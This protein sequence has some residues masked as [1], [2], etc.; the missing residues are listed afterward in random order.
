MVLLARRA[1]QEHFASKRR[2]GADNEGI[3]LGSQ[4]AVLSGRHFPLFSAGDQG[5]VVRLDQEALNCDVLFEGATQP[6]PV[7]L[8]HLRIVQPPLD[9]KHQVTDCNQS[10]TKVQSTNCSASCSVGST[11]YSNQRN[12]LRGCEPDEW[13]EGCPRG[14]RGAP[15]SAGGGAHGSTASSSM[16]D[17]A[18]FQMVF[19]ES[20]ASK[21]ES[22]MI[23]V[24]DTLAWQSTLEEGPEASTSSPAN[25]QV[26]K[27]KTHRDDRK[28]LEGGASPEV[29]TFA[30]SNTFD[31][32]GDAAAVS[33]AL[34]ADVV[35]A[36]GRLVRVETLEARIQQLLEK[37]RAE[38]EELKSQL[39]KATTLGRQQQE[40]V[41][42]LEQ[43]MRN[44]RGTGPTASTGSMVLR[45]TSVVASEMSALATA[46]VGSSLAVS[47]SML[48]IATD[49]HSSGTGTPARSC[50]DPSDSLGRSRPLQSTTRLASSAS[51]GALATRPSSPRLHL[52]ATSSHVGAGGSV[53]P[54]LANTPSSCTVLGPSVTLP[55]EPAALGIPS[56]SS[57]RALSASTT[58]TRWA[59]QSVPAH[60]TTSPRPA[61]FLIARPNGATQQQQNTPRQQSLTPPGGAT[62]ITP[63][64]FMPGCRQGA[65]Q[66]QQQQWQQEDKPAPSEVK[67]G[68]SSG[69]T[70]SPSRSGVGGGMLNSPAAQPQFVKPVTARVLP[71]GSS[72]SVHVQ[73]SATGSL[74]APTNRSPAAVAAAAAAAATASQGGGATTL[75][76]GLSMAPSFGRIERM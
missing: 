59:C 9:S 46:P 29:F 48:P 2:E 35:G 70:L 22:V 24:S 42:A 5:E 40:R 34:V 28:I 58:P 53:S 12:S 6:V 62:P 67:C 33:A 26:N 74:L 73:A 18:G 55:V 36:D 69:G 45:P 31:G 16:T 30:G 21:G 66:Q 60:T 39:E 72:A 32:F 71:V 15:S 17:L 11:A 1:L 65:Q 68:T 3:E 64:A 63:L 25:K 44:M 51:S 13:E 38:T 19:G 20:P 7:A 57:R 43:Q 41:A 27:N 56:G 61:L 10:S 4:V 47:N 14:V 76:A 50:C 23:S 54:R 8:R 37:H 49:G 75:T 52:S